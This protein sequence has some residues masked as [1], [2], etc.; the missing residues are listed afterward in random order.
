M[1]EFN[2]MKQHT[3]IV[4]GILLTLSGCASVQTQSK[5]TAYGN[6]TSYTPTNPAAVKIF[7]NFPP[8][9]FIR[10]GEIEIDSPNYAEVNFLGLTE[11]PSAFET[12]LRQSAAQ[13]GGDA[14]VIVD[15]RPTGMTGSTV[16]INTYQN[17]ATGSI[18]TSGDARGPQAYGR[19]IYGLVIK[20]I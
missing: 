13:I 16:S 14:V 19:R 15:D 2:F 8:Q 4:L 7:R 1:V 3:F 5:V 12:R 11:T 18:H 20:F 6:E 9:Q 10:L 17:P